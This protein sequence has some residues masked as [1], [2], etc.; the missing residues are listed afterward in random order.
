MK[1]FKT[2]SSISPGFAACFFYQGNKQRMICATLSILCACFSSFQPAFSQMS[3]QVLQPFPLYAVRLLDGPFKDA[4]QTDLSYIMLLDPDRLLAPFMKEAGISWK[5]AAY[6][7][8]ESSGLDGH[9]GG[10]YLS[11]LANMYAATGNQN[12]LQRLNY[13]V[14]MLDSCQRANGNGYIGGIPGGRAM[15][16][17]VKNGNFNA[18]GNSFKKKWVPFYN[19]HK[20]YAGL[21]DAYRIGGISNARQMVVEFA[22]WCINL[23]SGLSDA[24][25]QS[26][27][28]TEHG[29]MNESFADV[30]ALTGDK[31][32]LQLARR[33]SQRSLL[34]NL[35]QRVD[36]SSIIIH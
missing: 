30:F 11:A 21:L 24:Q 8:W 34:D 9:T 13:M 10:H 22:D 35:L 15:W 6:G 17:E 31:K 29:G 20:T 33:F 2:I 23:T 27:L 7:N 14:L 12:V 5:A 1:S 16:A 28:Q 18:A 36:R 26:L 19:I 3:K 32:Y 25:V 4:Q